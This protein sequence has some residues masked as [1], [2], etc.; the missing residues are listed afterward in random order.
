VGRSFLRHAI[1]VHSGS[2]GF[3]TLVVV[4][5]FGIVATTANFSVVDGAQLKPLPVANACRLAIVETAVRGKP[6]VPSAVVI[7]DFAPIL[8][9]TSN[10]RFS[11]DSA[12]VG[13]SI[14]IDRRALRCAARDA[15]GFEFPFD[16]EDLQGM[17]ALRTE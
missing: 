5:A 7:V 13:R 8:S 2:P 15:R 6:W 14:T 10:D 3:S 16:R 11:R 17:P 4:L 1:R 12:M 9:S